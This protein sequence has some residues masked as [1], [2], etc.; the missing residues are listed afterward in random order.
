VTNV[1]NKIKKVR[2]PRVQIS[3][4]VEDGGKSVKKELPFVVGVMGDFSGN[5]TKPLKAFK[6]R[7]FIQV[8][9]E[10]FNT[11]MSKMTPGLNIK[12]KN[13]LKNDD[14][15]LAVNLKFNSMDDFL[16]NKVAEQI[17]PLKKLLDIRL[18]LKEILGKA[19]CSEELEATLEKVLK[20]SEHLEGLSQSLNI[21]SSDQDNKTE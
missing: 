3:Y 5:P 21:N 19:D 10:N 2:K 11:V 12:V 20:N 15:E 4:E 7:K 18:K 14:S 9:G 13:T 6:Q 8:D 17:E 16:P 1:Y